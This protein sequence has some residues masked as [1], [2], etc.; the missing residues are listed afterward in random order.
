[1]IEKG[2]NASR[3]GEISG[4]RSMRLEPDG[5][6][7]ADDPV[8]GLMSGEEKQRLIDEVVS[9]YESDDFTRLSCVTAG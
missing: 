9:T 6:T 1:M 7:P 8:R 4:S 3:Q 2:K 5:G